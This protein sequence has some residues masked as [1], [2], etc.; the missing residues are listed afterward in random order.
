MHCIAA[1]TSIVCKALVPVT[2]TEES[3][4][5]SQGMSNCIK[6]K[7]HFKWL[8]TSY[9]CSS[10]T[11]GVC[12]FNQIQVINKTRKVI[13][14]LKCGELEKVWILGCVQKSTDQEIS[15]V[16]HEITLC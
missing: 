6:K 4:N 2:K 13:C 15:L 3:R 5:Y 10:S 16:T 11:Y 12:V 9:L 1:V 8:C 7:K 14:P